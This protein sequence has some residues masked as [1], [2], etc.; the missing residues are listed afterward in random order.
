MSQKVKRQI[1][2]IIL[3]CNSESSFIDDYLAK[4]YPIKVWDGRFAF[5]MREKNPSEFDIKQE[6]FHW[7]IAYET[8]L[9]NSI[10]S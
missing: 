10:I 9:A 2:A 1:F 7:Q 5:K 8:L 3:N 6:E 4:Y